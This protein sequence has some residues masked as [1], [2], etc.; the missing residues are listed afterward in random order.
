ML[1][2]KVEDKILLAQF[3]GRLHWS[4]SP[5]LKINHILLVRKS[6]ERTSKLL[7]KSNPH[8]ALLVATALI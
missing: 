4:C 3:G 6:R 8:I 7:L 5:H 1:D 2:I